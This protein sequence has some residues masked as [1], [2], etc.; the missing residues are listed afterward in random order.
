[1]DQLLSSFKI[2]VPASIYNK[3]PETSDLGKRIIKNSISMIS[4]LGFEVFT[5]KKLGV[6]IKSNESSIYRYFDNKHKLLVYLTSWYWAWLEYQ[7]VLET[8]S[9]ALPIEKLKKAITITTKTIEEDSK[10][11]HINEI[12][13]NNIIIN[14][15]S[16][17]FLT[18]EV[19]KENQNGYFTI[20]KRL[21]TRIKD[22]IILVNP[23]Y[24]YPASLASTIIETGLHQHFLKDHF[25]TI[26]D[27]K[28]ST[29]TQFISNLVFKTLEIKTP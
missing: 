6:E 27:C 2:S 8:Y 22:M 14:E 25:N 12:E 10:F 26:T 16:K 21:V 18:K 23:N 4:T 9:V 5:F 29:P 1:M 17:S 7:L 20:Y 13:L 19:D 3:D 24:K 11:T 28:N 15:N